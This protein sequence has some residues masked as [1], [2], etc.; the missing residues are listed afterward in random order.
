MVMSSQFSL[1]FELTGVFNPISQAASSLGRVA[2]VDTIRKS[3]S[4]ALTEVKLA[5][6]IG[7]HRVDPIIKTHFQ[8]AIAKSDQSIISRYFDIVLESGAGPTVQEALKNPALFSMVIQLSALA[9]SHDVESLA[10]AIVESIERMLQ[11]TEKDLDLVPDY[12]SL[13]GTIRACQQQT[14]GFRWSCL[15]QSVEQT[16]KDT[17]QT[18]EAETHPHTMPAADGTSL[19]DRGLPFSIL[20]ALIMWLQALQS[21]PDNRLL[22]V[23]CNKGISTIVVWCHHILSLSLKVN[24]QGCEV[25]FGDPPFRILLRCSRFEDVEATLMDPSGPQEPLFVLTPEDTTAYLSSEARAEARGYGLALLER[26]KTPQRHM[27]HCL[28]HVIALS[29]R[30][31]RCRRHHQSS[32]QA[33]MEQP[34]ES[35]QNADSFPEVYFPSEESLLRAGRFLF[36]QDSLNMTEIEA[37]IASYE[38][39]ERLNV[40]CILYELVKTCIALAR[41][42]EYDLGK[43]SHMSLSLNISGLLNHWSSKPLADFDVR[44]VCLLS[45][46]ERLCQLLL[47]QMFSRDYIN[48]AFLISGYGWSI[49]FNSVD[50][51]DPADDSLNMIRIMCGVPTR[52]GTRR[53]RIIDGP[54]RSTK[55]SLPGIGACSL[56]KMLLPS[57][58]SDAKRDYVLVGQHHS[59]AFQVTQTFSFKPTGHTDTKHMIGFRKMVEMRA[60]FA[61]LPQ[62]QHDNASVHQATQWIDSKC[63]ST[64]TKT[65]DDCVHQKHD[66]SEQHLPYVQLWPPG[67]ESRIS[68]SERIF[69]PS[70]H[71]PCDLNRVMYSKDPTLSE[72]KSL[73]MFVYV[74]EKPAARWLQLDTLYQFGVDDGRKMAI[75]SRNTC[76]E[77]ACQIVA[78]AKPTLLLL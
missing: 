54:S 23:K 74:S 8:A 24:I 31:A 5:S 59:D 40:S 56:W 25:Q 68:C 49:F 4:D 13:V 78:I 29:L 62:C 16:I 32:E 7:R 44:D 28:E 10:N 46:Y 67:G 69:Y 42:D 71:D 22:Y 2:L 61:L 55:L 65:D 77:C 63:H 66:P 18:A 50:V 3:G 73:T 70:R 11:E 15:Y 34:Q 17:I 33:E 48:S 20:Q 76:V 1:G 14:V 57:A 21:F 9:F 26:A 64:H 6:L 30:L 41:I 19:H 38:K 12:M 60:Q 52:R 39:R 51:D 45:S 43:C 27:R 58:I 36:A 35:S 72:D 53:A 75:R 47:G 37:L